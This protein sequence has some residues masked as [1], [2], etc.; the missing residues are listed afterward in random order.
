M[1]KDF[2]CA[3]SALL[4]PVVLIAEW[5]LLAPSSYSSLL[6][7]Y[8]KAVTDI[9]KARSGVLSFA[10]TSP[11]NGYCHCCRV[12][13][14]SLGDHRCGVENCCRRDSG[15]CRSCAPGCAV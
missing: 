3:L 14:Y 5:Q 9:K 7:A 1:R 8:P 15:C 11:T 12:Q 4:T 13:V 2:K 10:S 6:T